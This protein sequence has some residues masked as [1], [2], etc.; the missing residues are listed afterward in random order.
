MDSVICGL[1]YC[2]PY[3]YENV[4]LQVYEFPLYRLDS[5]TTVLSS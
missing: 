5:L 3:Q 4:V 2:G 1:S